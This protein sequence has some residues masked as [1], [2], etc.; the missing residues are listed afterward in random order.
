MS[1]DIL[2]NSIKIDKTLQNDIL[3]ILK[4]DD[5]KSSPHMNLFWQ[6]QKKLLASPK[7][8]RRYHPHIIRFCLSLH[9]KSPSPYRE[10]TSSG[11]LVLPSERVL[12]DYRN[13]FHP[14]PG[15]NEVNISRLQDMTKQL[16]DVQRYVVISFDEMKIQ[17][18]LVFDKHSNE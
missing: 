3:G 9:S 2:T 7:F 5:L 14:K 12:R 13:Y 11:V 4:E 1:W 6:Q 10:L 16:F 17:S 18:N 8:G 15:F